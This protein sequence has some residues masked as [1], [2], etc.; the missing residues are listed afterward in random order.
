MCHTFYSTLW[1]MLCL[2]N[3]IQLHKFIFNAVVDALELIIKQR[4]WVE[5][6][7]HY[8]DDF[9]SLESPRSRTCADNLIVILQTCAEVGIHVALNKCEGPSACL[10]FLGIEIDSVAMEMRLPQEKLKC[11]ENL[12]RAS[13][14]VRLASN[15]NCSHWLVNSAMLARLSNQE[16]SSSARW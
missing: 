6:I 11:S 12:S 16:V 15:G 7:I 4:E 9:I 5:H 8:L 13:M 1:T 14:V 10:T 3:Y 2:L